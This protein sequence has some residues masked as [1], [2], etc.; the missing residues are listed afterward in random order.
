MVTCD[1][2]RTLTGDAF[3]VKMVEGLGHTIDVILVNGV[4][5]EGDQIVAFVD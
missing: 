5:H 2:M 1:V 4:L 3:K